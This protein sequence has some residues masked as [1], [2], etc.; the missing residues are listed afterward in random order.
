MTSATGRVSTI[1]FFGDDSQ[2]P[3]SI[4]RPL[5]ANVGPFR[6]WLL[7][8]NS[9]GY[10][11]SQAAGITGLV[12]LGAVDRD[13][14][15]SATS[16][17]AYALLRNCWISGLKASTASND[18][19]VDT[20]FGIVAWAADNQTPGKLSNQGGNDRSM[21]G[22]CFGLD[23]DTSTPALWVGPVAWLVARST[24]I[25]DHIT[26]ASMAFPVDAAANTATAETVIP[27]AAGGLHG[28][29]T[30]VTFTPNASLTADD[31]DYATITVK[32]RDGSGGAAV[33][34]A[35]ITTKITGGSGDWTAFEPMSITLTATAADLLLLETDVLTLTVAKAASGVTIPASEL[36]VTMKVQ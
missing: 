7:G 20:D 27:R 3:W 24:H 36:R 33:T 6:G 13:Q 29:V 23:P 19:L 15:S 31:T 4:C 35:T 9:S 26:A 34:V 1:K 28:V 5:S 8:Q 11:V 18:G 17:N 30:S 21:L 2:L 25:A 14:D 22:L 12:S 32:K 16:G 10:A